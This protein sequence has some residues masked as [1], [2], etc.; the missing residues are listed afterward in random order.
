MSNTGFFACAFD[1]DHPLRILDIADDHDLLSCS[2]WNYSH[3]VEIISL[4]L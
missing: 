1:D 3:K 2:W 4:Y